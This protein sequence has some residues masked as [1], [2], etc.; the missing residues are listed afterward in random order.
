M[1]WPNDYWQTPPELIAKIDEFYEGEWFD[2]CPADPGFDGLAMP[3]PPK[4]YVNPPFSQYKKWAEYG[5]LQPL[6][7]LWICHHDSSTERM[8]LLFPGAT[9]GLLLD[10]VSFIH[11]ETGKPKGTDIAKSQTLLYRG[12]HPGRFRRVF[13]DIAWILEQSVSA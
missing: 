12:N 11:P 2:P 7:Q 4:V 10:R 6:E 5:R 8:Q 3:W 1:K 9:V 13:Q